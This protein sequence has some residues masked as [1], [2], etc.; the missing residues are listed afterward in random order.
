MVTTPGGTTAA[1]IE[2]MDANHAQ[3]V[4][5]RAISMA[6]QRSRELGQ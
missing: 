6:T 3:D 4:I 2:H 1:A 5:A